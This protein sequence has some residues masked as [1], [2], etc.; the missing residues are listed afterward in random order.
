MMS[1]K[2]WAKG[3]D[4]VLE[5]YPQHTEHTCVSMALHDTGPNIQC[6]H[7]YVQYILY[8]MGPNILYI[9]MNIPLYNI[10]PNMQF[11]YVNTPLYD[12][13]PII[14]SIPMW[15]YPYMTW[16]DVQ[17]IYIIRGKSFNAKC[18]RYLAQHFVVRVNWT[19]PFGPS[20]QSRWA[21]LKHSALR[22]NQTL[23]PSCSLP[24]TG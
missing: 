5:E 19:L 14:Q 22:G 20:M 9:P 11:I 24:P 12:T 23:Y 21:G 15:V 13:R 16:N 10:G 17:W 3:E 6:I 2:V 7:T 1:E 8:G 18:H 4:S